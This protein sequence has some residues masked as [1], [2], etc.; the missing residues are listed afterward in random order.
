MEGHRASRRTSCF[1]QQEAGANRGLS[2][3]NQVYQT[4]LSSLNRSLLGGGRE[5]SAETF[6][7]TTDLLLRAHTVS[8]PKLKCQLLSKPNGFYS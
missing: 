3:L 6:S 8:S 5:R 4:F 7:R 2:D 1:L